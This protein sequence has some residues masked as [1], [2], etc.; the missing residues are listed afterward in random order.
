TGLEGLKLGAIAYLLPFLWCFNEGL[1]L[2]GS[3][4]AKIYAVGAAT[5]GAALLAR[6]LQTVRFNDW[7]KFMVGG[8]YVIAGCIVGGSTLWLG[9]ES[10]WNLAAVGVGIALFAATHRIQVIPT[11]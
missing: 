10:L 1:I 3:F 11:A 4:A 2:E 6:A 8:G 9:A 5:I 7:T